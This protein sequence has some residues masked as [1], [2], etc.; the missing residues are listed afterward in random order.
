M[1]TRNYFLR[2]TVKKITLLTDINEYD[3]MT[4]DTN[5]ITDQDWEEIIL[6]LTAFTRSLMKGKHWFRGDKTTSF[7]M[8][9]EVED[10]VFE[11]IRK[12]L[13]EPNKFDSSKGDLLDYL[14]FNL[15]RSL[16]SNDLVKSENKR[17]DDL[18]V[19]AL[20][21]DD[22]NEAASNYYER[23][24]PFTEALFDDEIDYDLVKEYIS[25]EIQKDLPAENIFLGIYTFG[26]KRREIIE[27]FQMSENEF[28]N[29]MRRLKTII[30]RASIH[31]SVKKH[32]V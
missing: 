31:F 32:A 8:G 11:A 3:K 9:K 28:D 19:K 7:L 26:L 23:L 15:I 17:T 12:Y 20:E 30:T 27:E 18:F 4:L 21:R 10:Y 6:R 24:L 25:K 16:V 14:K 2:G 22:E 29:G 13:E 1:L 5:S